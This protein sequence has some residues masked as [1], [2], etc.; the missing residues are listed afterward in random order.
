MT[1]QLLP[2]RRPQ[3][4]SHSYW[5]KKLKLQRSSS[6]ECR[7]S[8]QVTKEAEHAPIPTPLIPVQ[9]LWGKAR[10]EG[11]RLYSPGDPP[12]SVV[13]RCDRN[14]RAEHRVFRKHEFVSLELERDGPFPRAPQRRDSTT[15]PF[16]FR[17]MKWIPEGTNKLRWYLQYYFSD[18]RNNRQF[19]FCCT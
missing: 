8:Q 4:K 5:R 2:P 12:L 18:G 9:C 15:A 14:T 7:A 13:F 1:S 3:G 6:G 17:G 10:G 19:G 16:L 11:V